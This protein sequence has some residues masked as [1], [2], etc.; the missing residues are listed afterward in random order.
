MGEEDKDEN[1]QDVELSI[2][3]FQ[4]PVIDAMTDS[5]FEAHTHSLA[6]ENY[7]SL[8]VRRIIQHQPAVYDQ[9]DVHAATVAEVN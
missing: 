2:D 3:I 9:L 1:R 5:A 4:T 8:K 7:S 6:S